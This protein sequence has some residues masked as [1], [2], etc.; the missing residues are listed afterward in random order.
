MAILFL[1]GTTEPTVYQPCIPQG[2]FSYRKL[3]SLHENP[4]GDYTAAER[5][6]VAGATVV[7]QIICTYILHIKC[8]C[9]SDGMDKH[10][11]FLHLF[12]QL[13]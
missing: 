9:I 11:K 13:I 12:A 10:S 5:N 6:Y 1:A 3:R 4:P 8:A 2:F 7:R